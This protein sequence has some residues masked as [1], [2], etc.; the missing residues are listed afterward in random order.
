VSFPFVSIGTTIFSALL[1][2]SHSQAR[3]QSR[4]S[5]YLH[6]VLRTSKPRPPAQLAIEARPIY[7]HLKINCTGAFTNAALTCNNLKPS[8]KLQNIL[9]ILLETVHLY[10]LCCSRG[11]TLEVGF[12]ST[13]PVDQH[14]SKSTP[15]PL[16]RPQSHDLRSPIASQRT[17]QRKYLVSAFDALD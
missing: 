2:Y 15:A 14:A 3:T 11:S 5:G 6:H 17:Y 8:G 7:H 12:Y 9:A 1:P 4:L 16:Q 13:R 10:I